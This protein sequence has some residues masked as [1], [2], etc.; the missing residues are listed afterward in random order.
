MLCRQSK[1]QTA[2]IDDWCVL[3]TAMVRSFSVIGDKPT[4]GNFSTKHADYLVG[5]V[6]GCA[7]FAN[8][9]GAKGFCLEQEKCYLSDDLE[10]DLA[11][12]QV[13]TG[14]K[15]GKGDVCMPVVPCVV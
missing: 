5:S 9:K 12:A 10:A 1:T 2:R 8:K 15:D 7:Y 6:D 13:A 3:M 14:C 4:C 11:T